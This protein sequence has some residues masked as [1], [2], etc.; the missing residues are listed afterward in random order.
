MFTFHTFSNKHIKHQVK[1]IKANDWV[2]LEDEM[3][4]NRWADYFK[5]NNTKKN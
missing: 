3:S 4:R 1:N 5:V 2:Y